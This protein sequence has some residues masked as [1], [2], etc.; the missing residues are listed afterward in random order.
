MGDCQYTGC[1]DSSAGGT[2]VLDHEMRKNRRRVGWTGISEREESSVQGIRGGVD[3]Y[4]VR[5]GGVEGVDLKP[6]T[7]LPLSY[8]KSKVN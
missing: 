5:S 7:S 4:G 3:R 6:L 2:G 8:P 1:R